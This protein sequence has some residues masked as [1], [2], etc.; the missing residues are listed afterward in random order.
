MTTKY[1]SCFRIILLAI[2]SFRFLSNLL[3]RDCAFP[4]IMLVIPD[5]LRLKDF[6]PSLRGGISYLSGTYLIKSI[7]TS[8][9]TVCLVLCLSLLFLLWL[10]ISDSSVAHLY[11]H[12]A[13]FRWVE[14]QNSIARF[15]SSIVI[16]S[17]Q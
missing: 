13:S 1:R 9:S 15:F 11:V 4:L 17:L 16:I 12:I 10:G 5:F 6:F 8:F 3:L 7:G 2:S 14:T